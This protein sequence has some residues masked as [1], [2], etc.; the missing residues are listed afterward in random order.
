MLHSD[1]INQTYCTST[2]QQKL[3]MNVVKYL[4]AKETDISDIPQE[5][6][7]PSPEVEHE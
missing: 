7:E 3:V 4:A 6:V 5:L 1:Y 2:K